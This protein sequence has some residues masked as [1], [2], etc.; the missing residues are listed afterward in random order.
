MSSEQFVFHTPLFYVR[1]NQSSLCFCSHLSKRAI[2][3]K[4][5]LGHRSTGRP[6]GLAVLS[7][8]SALRCIAFVTAIFLAT[9]SLTAQTARDGDFSV[10]SF[11]RL[12]WDLDA[13]SNHPLRDQNGRK[14]AL[15]KVITSAEGLD[16][17]VGVMGIVAVRQE[18]GEVWVYVPEKVMKITVRHKDFGVIRDYVFPEPI[19]SA[20][21]YEMVLK[22]PA[23]PIVEKEIIV[24]DSIVYLPSPTDSSSVVTPRREPVGLS[25]SGVFAFPDC[26]GG[27]MLCWEKYRWGCYVKAVSNF[28]SSA[29]AYDCLSDGTTSDGYIWT[30]GRS[31]VSRLSV[32]TG[33]VFRTCDWLSLSAGAGYG[34]RTLLWEDSSGYWSRVSDRSPRGVAAD[35][36]LQFRIRRLRLSAG[37]S[38]TAFRR[39]D[40][41]IAVGFC[42]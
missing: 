15:I 11:R 26:S 33:L 6:A 31:R 3:A 12:E 8:T 41:E 30:S 27:L 36:G 40:G 19:E 7:E 32:T 28:R 37:L 23:P 9:F 29:S 10:Q 38:T 17:D 24:R 35:L 21:T 2:R 25:V 13:R 16:F 14:A 18:V 5:R 34:F 20:A 22:T 42:F 1:H 4:K 39:L